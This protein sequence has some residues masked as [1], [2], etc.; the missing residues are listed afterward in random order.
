MQPHHH[1][2]C[3][4]GMS[5]VETV[6]AMMVFAVFSLL[7]VAY[8]VNAQA[9]GS[10]NTQRVAAANLAAQ[11]IEVVRSSRTLDVLDGTTVLPAAPRV[12][13][14]TY[15]LTQHVRFVAGPDGAS[16][17]TGGNDRL[18]YKLVTVLVTWPGMGKVRPVRSDTLKTLGIGATQAD[19][20]KGSAAVAVVD[21][22][23]K[24][25][26]GVSV[27]LTPGPLTATTGGD[28]CVV[29]PNLPTGVTHTAR[30]SAVDHV[31][32]QGE[33]NPTS[34]FSLTAGKVTKVSTS[35]APRAALSLTATAP[36]PD[37]P[38]PATLGITVD[39]ANLVPTRRRGF[40]DC[41][42][43]GTAPQNCV[44]GTPRLA[45]AIFPGV[46]EAWAGRCADARPATPPSATAG[47]SAG[48]LTSSL[49]GVRLTLGATSLIGSDGRRIYAEHAAD[50]SC[51][52]GEVYELGTSAA[53]DR[54]SSLPIGTW[55][56]VSR[57][58]D[59]SEYYRGSSFSVTAGAVTPQS[60]G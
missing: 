21:H 60:H 55:T 35:F 47:T 20:R 59:G 44:Q 36:A 43:T 19:A 41:S 51:P 52:A 27:Q 5:L 57:N 54:R 26:A 4:D 56:L 15:T 48:A 1:S 22:E 33:P 18:A 6:V 58:P 53:N 38:V 29:F 8:L 14:T 28:G 24:P 37:Y 10:S 9:V 30:L 2:H 39:N 32:L 3:D 42:T 13:G 31:G 50:S 7:A 34:A 12:A 25:R 45:S 17:C 16:V 46:Y 11:Q 49:G 23:G 40:A